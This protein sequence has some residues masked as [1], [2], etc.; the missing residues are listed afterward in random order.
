MPAKTDQIG[1]ID[2]MYIITY[3]QLG[4]R[5]ET[6]ITSKNIVVKSTK[7]YEEIDTMN[8][9][10]ISDVSTNTYNDTILIKTISLNNAISS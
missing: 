10:L 6:N 2:K 5:Y 9:L 8:R 3:D 1:K 7:N 4:N